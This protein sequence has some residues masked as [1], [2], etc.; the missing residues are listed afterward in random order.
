MYLDLLGLPVFG[1][2]SSYEHLLQM[3]ETQ[4]HHFETRQAKKPKNS[5]DDLDIFVECEV[6]SADVA[7][8]IT[9]LRRVAEDVK[10]SREE[11]GKKSMHLIVLFCF[12]V[13]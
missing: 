3:F 9:S 10:T 7:V 1:E 4:I 13:Q 2:A 11:E 5:A 12:F 6:H 8:I